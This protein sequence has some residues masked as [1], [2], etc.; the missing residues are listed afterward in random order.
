MNETKL[1]TI[2]AGA[3]LSWFF[4]IFSYCYVHA[5]QLAGLAAIVASIFTALAAFE[6]WRLCRTQRK[7]LEEL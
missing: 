6:K 2:I 4:A 5:A 7:R 1:S 3:V